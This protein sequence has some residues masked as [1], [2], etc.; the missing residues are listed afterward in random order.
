MPGLFAG[1][2]KHRRGRRL[3]PYE[4]KDQ[5][6]CET[7][8]EE[9][10]PEIV[11]DDRVWQSIMSYSS[12][13]DVFRWRR[14]NH[15]LHSLVRQR[16]EKIIYLDVFRKTQKDLD[17]QH[18]ITDGQ[19]HKA[20]IRQQFHKATGS[21]LLLRIDAHKAELVVNERWTLRDV[22][23]LWSAL[24]SLGKYAL[25]VQLDAAVIELI[26]AGL[27]SMDLSRWYSFQCYLQAFNENEIE[28]LHLH[29]TTCPQRKEPFFPQLKEMT[30]RLSDGDRSDYLS[31]LLDYSVLSSAVFNSESVQL[32][33]LRLISASPR[34][35]SLPIR[36]A[37]RHAITFR[38]WVRAGELAEKYTQQYII[39]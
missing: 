35:C 12:P 1:C 3:A 30:I 2:L 39:A 26:V 19:F 32:V 28:R 10:Q 8:E 15:R 13:F 23:R 33:R 11:F 4:P 21:Q 18:H 20:T 9:K 22:F 25:N 34:S 6:H 37:R 29:C 36:C 24:T 16:F 27:S 38:R 17:H 7:I 31:R 5:R 14:V